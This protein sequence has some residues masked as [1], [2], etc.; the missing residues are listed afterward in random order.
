M[1]IDRMYVILEDRPVSREDM[2]N[3]MSGVRDWAYRTGR[4]ATKREG[5][6]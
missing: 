2:V 4:E 6:N 1:G 3:V 5:G